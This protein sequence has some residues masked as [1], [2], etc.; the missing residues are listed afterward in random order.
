MA[1]SCSAD[2][3]NVMYYDMGGWGDGTK[4]SYNKDYK[5]LEKSEQQSSAVSIFVL[6]SNF[7]HHPRW[8]APMTVVATIG[9]SS[10]ATRETLMV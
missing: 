4:A 2:V 10:L 7:R 5:A 8:Q 3:D 6:S 1:K 9:P